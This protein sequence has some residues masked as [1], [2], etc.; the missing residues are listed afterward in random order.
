MALDWD[1]YVSNYAPPAQNVG[2]GA[3]E[4][5]V[6]GLMRNLTEDAR[7]KKLL[8]RQ[9]GE[10]EYRYKLQEERIRQK[11]LEALTGG[12]ILNLDEE[13]RGLTMA[14]INTSIINPYNE[15][16]SSMYKADGSFADP[17]EWKDSEVYD[18]NRAYLN[19]IDVNNMPA[20]KKRLYEQKGLLNAGTFM[21]SYKQYSN[22]YSNQLAS[23]LHAYMKDKDLSVKEMSKI[24]AKK[25][26]LRNLLKRNPESLKNYPDIELSLNPIEGILDPVKD[27]VADYITKPFETAVENPI[28]TATGVGTAIA[29]KSFPKPLEKVATGASKTV[30]PAYIANKTVGALAEG[31]AK[32]LGTTDKT[33]ALAKE[34]TE[35]AMNMVMAKIQKYGVGRILRH[36]AK[37]LGFPLAARTLGKIG[38]G[39]LGAVGTY[40]IG[41]GIMLAWTAKDL[42]DIYDIVKNMD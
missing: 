33:A 23:N 20:D 31:T 39:S 24:L 13:Y 12:D 15:I 19:H 41:T 34:G 36:I 17:S 6:S 37:T 16:Y 3:L 28:L 2:A 26:H 4:R 38:L 29:A 11:K 25:P 35:L 40:G 8:E 10:E 9:R 22:L 27:I 14:S 32:T 42:Y 7:Y 1:S 5:G 21:Q 30:L 18:P